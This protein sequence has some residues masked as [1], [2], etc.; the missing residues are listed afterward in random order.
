MIRVRKE[1]GSRA[2]E[3]KI[4]TQPTVIIATHD[5]DE[6]CFWLKEAARDP[7]AFEIE[8]DGTITK[9]VKR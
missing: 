7:K 6:L 1:S 4:G 8:S 2:I 3:F 5:V 9:R